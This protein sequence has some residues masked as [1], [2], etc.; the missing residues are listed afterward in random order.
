[1]EVTAASLDDPDEFPPFP[2]A[3]MEDGIS[4]DM[5]NDGLSHFERGGSPD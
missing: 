3:W 2:H 4:W 1:L 5:A